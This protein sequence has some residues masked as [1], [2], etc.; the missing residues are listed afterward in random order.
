MLAKAIAESVSNLITIYA[1]ASRIFSRA[2]GIAKFFS[3]DCVFF[4]SSSS[5][6]FV[7]CLVIPCHSLLHQTMSA[8]RYGT[9]LACVIFS[10]VYMR[11]ESERG[12]ER[13]ENFGFGH[14]RWNCGNDSH[15]SRSSIIQESFPQRQSAATCM[16]YLYKESSLPTPAA[17][18][19]F[20]SFVV[21]VCFL[22]LRR[23]R[24]RE[25]QTF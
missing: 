8:L 15:F 5:S 17:V 21:V 16:N 12:R 1:R 14:S 2:H 22:F 19:V 20:R 3:R 25:S 9:R 4:Y 6:F 11:L 18:N 23:E 7:M 13:V 24:E 10:Q